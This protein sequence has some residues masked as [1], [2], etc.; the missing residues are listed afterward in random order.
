MLVH[1]S[2]E[3]KFPFRVAAFAVVDG[4]V[5]AGVRASERLGKVS[6]IELKDARGFSPDAELFDGSAGGRKP[7][8]AQSS[9]R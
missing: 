2:E 8:A 7:D 6:A 4:N 9:N 5:G 3:L 1:E